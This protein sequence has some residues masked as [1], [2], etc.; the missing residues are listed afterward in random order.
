MS[1]GLASQSLLCPRCGVGVDVQD[2][3][4]RGCG[5]PLGAAA[6]RHELRKT[7]TVVFCDLVGSTALGER[8]DAEALRHLFG[9][10]YAEM[11]AVLERH[12]GLVEKFIGDAV[13][14]VFGVPL[15]HEDDALRAV[16]AAVEMRASL[17]R[18][19]DELERDSG[20]RIGVRIGVNTGEVVAGDLGPGASF[21]SG[22]AVNVAARLEQAAGPGEILIGPCHA[23]A[24]R[25]TRSRS[26][27]VPPLDLHGKTEPVEAFRLVG[28][29]GGRG[30]DQ[31]ALET[32]FVGREQELALLREAFDEAVAEPGCRL[33]TVVGEPGIGKTRLLSEF[34]SS[35]CGQGAGA[36]RSLSP[37]R[38]GD[39]LLA[40]GRDR[41]RA[42]RRRS[43]SDAGRLACLRRAGRAGRAIS[44]WVRSACRIGSAR[45]RRHS[46]RCAACSRRSPASGRSSSCSRICTGPSRPSCNWSS[47]WPVA[48]PDHRSCCSAA[49]RDELLDT[50]P[51]LGAAET[52]RA[53][54][55]ARSPV[56]GG[57]REL[58]DGLDGRRPRLRGDARREIARTGA[59]NPLFLEQLLAL[60]AEQ[61]DTDQE[62]PLPATIK[63]LLA[64]R[65]DRLTVP[66]RD[67]LERA[68][69]EGVR[70][71]PR[72]GH[73]PA[74]GHRAGRGRR[75]VS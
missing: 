24:A 14:A 2:R 74:P 71:P 51:G 46:G 32:V 21:A 40:A 16:R 7:V 73:R 65:L 45:S 52:E 42:R 23:P 50:R 17:E 22:D 70:L 75:P 61:G 54:T 36:D 58:V 38:G 56:R 34:A 25:Q 39:H 41:A 18:L 72:P 49:A 31:P 11:R 4:C 8:L 20:V 67:L 48:R 64:A 47:T 13:V 6:S 37:L 57:G 44:S 62:L 33:V 27:P 30:G 60:Q 5:A 29:G 66:E 55:P 59:G 28:G 3:F 53:A 12:G 15:V 1:V 19:N 35:V 69:V 68:A 43:G 63:A 9:R 10:Y 26:R